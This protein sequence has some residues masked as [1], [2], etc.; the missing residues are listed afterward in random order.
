M[1]ALLADTHE[2]ILLEGAIRQARA[3]GLPFAGSVPPIEAWAL[4]EAGRAVLVDVRSTEERR[5]VGY[6]PES[7]H[8]AWATGTA[9]T[10]NPRFLR[11]LEAKVGKNDVLLFL[12][13]SGKR[14]A[15]AAEAATK[16]GFT[17]VFNVNEGFEGDLDG[18][19]RRGNVGGWRLRGLKWV[20]D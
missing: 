14:S 16:I 10:R 6:V 12:C 18:D 1:S 17:A 5:F 11:E 20:Q 19:R 3:S 8:V 15:I 2:D 4:V 13:R 7:L 9:L